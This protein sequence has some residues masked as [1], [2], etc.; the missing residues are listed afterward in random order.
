MWD[1]YGNTRG[2]KIAV[3]NEDIGAAL[4]GKEINVG[5]EIIKKLEEN[6][7]IGWQFVD[8]EDAQEGVRTGKYYASMIVPEEFFKQTFIYNRKYN[9]RTNIRIYS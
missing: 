1:P 3:V 7:N 8:R 2:I 9:N 6:E 5:E 4:D